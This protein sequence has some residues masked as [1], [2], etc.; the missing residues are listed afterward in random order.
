MDLFL[1][2]SYSHQRVP[3]C[4][5]ESGLA[6]LYWVPLAFREQMA[7]LQTFTVLMNSGEKGRIEMHENYPVEQRTGLG[8]LWE[9]SLY[10]RKRESIFEQTP[11]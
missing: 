5:P 2:P 3:V 6:S 8:W 1:L 7:H 10:R 4:M 11:N 9:I